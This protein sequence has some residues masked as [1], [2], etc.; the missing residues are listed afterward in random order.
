MASDAAISRRLKEL[1]EKGDYKFT[2]CSEAT[3]EIVVDK[4]RSAYK[5]YLFVEKKTL[6]TLVQRILKDIDAKLQQPAKPAVA[7]L[8]SMITSS[9]GRNASKRTLPAGDAPT[10][11]AEDKSGVESSNAELMEKFT[12][13]PG[14]VPIKAE[15]AAP[16]TASKKRKTAPSTRGGDN[17]DSINP[18]L[19][20]QSFC[21]FW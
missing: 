6:T 12:D 9:Y 13:E 21:S 11:D 3:A 10:V 1:E 7:S 16:S 18:L 19:V 8:N 4:L 17:N 14:A 2:D 5:D 20:K 15:K